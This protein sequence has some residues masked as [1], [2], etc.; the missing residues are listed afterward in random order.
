MTEFELREKIAFALQK[1][2]VGLRNGEI[3]SA[4]NLRITD[5]DMREA[6][7]QMVD[8]RYLERSGN[9]ATTRYNL[10][11]QG[12][13]MF[14]SGNENA[15]IAQ[16]PVQ[17]TP[18]NEHIEPETTECVEKTPENVQ[19]DAVI[20]EI[21]AKPY[22]FITDSV[23]EDFETRAKPNT[24]EEKLAELLATA[25]ES[26]AESE[27]ISDEINS[28][29]HYHGET[30]DV[31]DVIEDF[32]TPKMIEGYLMGNVVKYVLRYQKKGGVQSLKKA[33][34]YLNRTV[35]DFDLLNEA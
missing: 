17:K 3:V 34:W 26:F 30:M 35:Q 32:F 9:C 4:V 1:T 12:R 16:V 23:I 28:P 6:L 10:T 33:Q 24:D 22:P 11:P 31:I 8:L 18:E 13:L 27:P 5:K 21:E 19:V 29:A 25:F 7:R 20:D 15:P 2:T 14:I